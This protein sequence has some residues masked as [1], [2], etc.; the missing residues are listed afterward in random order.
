MWTYRQTVPWFSSIF[1]TPIPTTKTEPS[2]A[3]CVLSCLSSCLGWVSSPWFSWSTA[4][5]ESRPPDPLA[6]PPELNSLDSLS[7][8]A[9]TKQGPVNELNLISPDRLISPC[10]SRFKITL[11]SHSMVGV[12]SAPS[13]VLECAVVGAASNFWYALLVPHLLK[14]TIIPRDRPCVSSRSH[15]ARDSRV[16]V[17]QTGGLHSYTRC[18]SPCSACCPKVFH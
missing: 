12:F 10:P 3:P 14:P 16:R 5:S 8:T 4:L 1:A 11:L 7:T 17:A 6:P 18:G 13:L 2:W 15:C 9:W